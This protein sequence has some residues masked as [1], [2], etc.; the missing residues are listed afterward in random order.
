MSSRGRPVKREST[1]YRGLPT[2]PEESAME[3]LEPM[4]LEDYRP[5]TVKGNGRATPHDG[6]PVPNSATQSSM[7]ISDMVV[8]QSIDQT[9][10]IVQGRMY[11][12]QHVIHP[13]NIL[14]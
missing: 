14:S 2:P 5:D 8:N 13:A 3:Y 11:L 7:A 12:F 6:L 1:E 10:P 9:H 4:K